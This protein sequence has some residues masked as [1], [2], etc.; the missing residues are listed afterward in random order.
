MTILIDDGS[1]PGPTALAVGGQTFVNGTAS[2]L[3]MKQFLTHARGYPMTYTSTTLPT[4]F[5]LDNNTGILSFNGTGTEGTYSDIAIGATDGEKAVAG[6][7]FTIFVDPAPTVSFDTHPMYAGMSGAFY[8]NNVT[9]IFDDLEPDYLIARVLNLIAVQPTGMWDAS[10][11]SRMSL[12]RDVSDRNP[13]L[14]MLVHDAPL[15]FSGYEPARNQNTRWR[16]TYAYS[17]R[18]SA[19]LYR[20]IDTVDE[21]PFSSTGSQNSVTNQAQFFMRAADP[22]LQERWATVVRDLLTG[23]NAY[24]PVGGQDMSDVMSYFNDGSPPINPKPGFKLLTN[25]DKGTVHQVVS[26]YS[27]GWPEV[28]ELSNQPGPTT[29]GTYSGDATYDTVDSWPIGFQKGNNTDG[30]IGCQVIAYKTVGSGRSRVIIKAL[31]A[32]ADNNQRYSIAAGDRYNM[33]NPNSGTTSVDHNADGVPEDPRDEGFTNWHNGYMAMYDRAD[34]L[35]EATTGHPT[36]RGHN[37][38]QGMLDKRITGFPHPH[39]AFETLDYGNAEGFDGKGNFEP[40]YANASQEYDTSNVIV[41]NYLHGMSFATSFIRPNPGGWHSDKARGVLMYVRNY[42]PD[43]DFTYVNSPAGRMA[44]RIRW[45]FVMTLVAGIRTAFNASA[46]SK[47]NV[48]GRPVMC[49]EQF[50]DFTIDYATPPP[51]WTF[52]PEGGGDGTGGFPIGAVTMET[53]DAGDAIYMR[54]IGSRHIVAINLADPFSGYGSVYRPSHLTSGITPRDPEDTITSTDFDALYT[55]GYLPDGKVLQHVDMSTY[56]NQTMTDALRAHPTTSAI[57]STYSYGPQQ[58]HPQDS[59][60][61]TANGGGGT[62]DLDTNP[63]IARDAT[64]NDGTSVNMAADYGLGPL[65]AVV[66]EVVDAP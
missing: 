33:Q 23:T 48:P 53:A 22:G 44:S 16:Y 14:R 30:F 1:N 25:L 27:D 37:F 13:F 54:P 19:I 18:Q 32:V 58:A 55:K 38:G 56:V 21:L 60:G 29:G 36:G 35:I 17:N 46:A 49:E 61:T 15:R 34:E 66:W 43:D 65:E 24:L 3:D 47:N 4:G 45:F 9:R 39:A 40:L 50:L 42:G 20:D 57:W 51:C 2:T 52:D 31:P 59:S 6:Q 41:D 28:I 64:L 5:S 12:F 63:G 10:R 8:S 11:L 62:Y 7:T 26:V